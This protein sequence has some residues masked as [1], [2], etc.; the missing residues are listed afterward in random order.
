MK[1]RDANAFTNEIMKAIRHI[2]VGSW[3]EEYVIDSLVH[4]SKILDNCVNLDSYELQRLHDFIKHRFGVNS[5]YYRI[6]FACAKEMLKPDEGTQTLWAEVGGVFLSDVFDN[7]L[8]IYSGKFVHLSGLAEGVECLNGRIDASWSFLLYGDARGMMFDKNSNTETILDNILK[9]D[10][11]LEDR[12][13][14]IKTF[15]KYD[16][17]L[18]LCAQKDEKGVHI[19]WLCKVGDNSY[20]NGM[21]KMFMLFPDVECINHPGDIQEIIL[22]ITDIDSLGLLCDFVMGGITN[23]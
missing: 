18:P 11:W 10:E 20:L 4:R 7:L 21:E 8:C 6:M 16:I 5:V 1:N 2:Q 12:V 19:T 13:E 22:H 15:H 23:E 17:S 3:L 14:I 9:A